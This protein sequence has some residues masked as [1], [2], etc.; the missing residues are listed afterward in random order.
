M[1]LCS[2]LTYPAS[3]HATPEQDKSADDDLGVAIDSDN[4][5]AKDDARGPHDEDGSYLT[6]D[7]SD[8]AMLGL[9]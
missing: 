2:S 8:L 6:Y 5:I 4:A 9:Q 1:R 3:H 7:H